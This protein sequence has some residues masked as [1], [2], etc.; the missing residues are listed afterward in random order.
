[1][2]RTHSLAEKFEPVIYEFPVK[3]QHDRTGWMAWPEGLPVTALASTKSGARLKLR[4]A[5]R[6]Y[7]R[8]TLRYGEDAG[9]ALTNMG[10][11]MKAKRKS[12]EVIVQDGKP[13]AVIVPIEEYRTM[14]E[15]L[16][17]ASDLKA[18]ATLRKKTLKFRRLDDF[19]KEYTP[20]V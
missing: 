14:L 1:M 13:T 5:V 2:R 20:S 11:K 7:F 19:L 17:D 12:P 16:E 3:Y 15:R 18:L 9:H 8:S 6:A 4:G 10:G